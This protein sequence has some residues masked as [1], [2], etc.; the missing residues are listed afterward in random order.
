M[1]APEQPSASVPGEGHGTGVVGW[2]P[3]ET[4]R[5]GKKVIIF[6]PRWGVTEGMLFD[7][8]DWGLAT[9]NGQIMKAN[10]T[11]WMPLPPPP[12]ASVSMGTSAASEPIPPVEG[13]NAELLGTGAFLLDRLVD[14]ENRITTDEDAREFSGHVSPAIARF[15]AAIATATRNSGDEG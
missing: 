13:V 5:R 4:A 3:I 6:D 12:A 8:G 7:S 9:F 2:Q 10:P 14:F 11:H 1:T 15:H